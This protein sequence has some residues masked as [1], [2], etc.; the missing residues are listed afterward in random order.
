VADRLLVRQPRGRVLGGQ[1]RPA[2]RLLLVAGPHEMRG[3]LGQ[4][5]LA[6]GGALAGQ[7]PPHR[8]VQPRPRRAV[9][10]PL[11]LP[12]RLAADLRPQRRRELR[13]DHRG[14]RQ[15]LVGGGVEAG[16]APPD[17][18]TDPERDADGA[19]RLQRPRRPGLRQQ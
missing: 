14:D 15:Q 16:Q 11:R 13:A 2:D 7:R 3:Q 5:H 4:A 17:G 1:H 10:Q 8:Q 12:G 19:C 18:L 6:A 9:Q